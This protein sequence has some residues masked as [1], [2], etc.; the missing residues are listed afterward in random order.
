MSE[1]FDD[2]DDLELDP[3]KVSNLNDM[4]EHGVEDTIVEDDVWENALLAGKMRE[5]NP[6]FRHFIKVIG[7]DPKILREQEE[8]L[9]ENC[10]GEFK[11]LGWYY[12]RCHY[13]VAIGFTETSDAVMYRLRWN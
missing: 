10:I 13:T 3:D 8:W 1:E 4:A 7:Y 11:R 9:A 2:N 5:K 12:P 6:Q